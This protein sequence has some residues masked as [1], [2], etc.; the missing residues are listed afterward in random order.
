LGVRITGLSFEANTES[1][2]PDAGR[3]SIGVTEV[4]PGFP[5]AQ[6]LFPGD[7]ILGIDGEMFGKSMDWNQF[8]TI[9]TSHMAGTTVHFAVLRDGKTLDVAV[10]TVF[11]APSE[12]V[13]A[14]MDQREEATRRFLQTLHSGVK[15]MHVVFP[16]ASGARTEGNQRD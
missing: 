4:Q 10:Q 5:A 3:V 9:V 8:R 1:E 2:G 6:A 16:A 15:E 7:R 14:A 12:K 13:Q 11:L